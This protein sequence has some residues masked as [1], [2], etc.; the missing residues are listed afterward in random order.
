M[1]RVVLLIDQHPER[2]AALGRG[3]AEVGY[4]VIQTVSAEQGLSY[5]EALDVALVVA[6]EE[7]LGEKVSV[8]DLLLRSTTSLLLLSD[9]NELD[10]TLP[11]QARRLPLAA[12]EGAQ[13]VDRVRLMLL[14]QELGLEP[15][16]D[17]AGLVGELQ[18]DPFL[19]ITLKLESIRFSGR[20]ELPR[21]NILWYAG[22]VVEVVAGTHKG[23]KAFSRLSTQVAGAFRLVPKTRP[24]AESERFSAR[25]LIDLAIDEH[26]GRRPAPQRRLHLATISGLDASVY[27]PLGQSILETA[28]RGDTVQ[29]LLESTQLPDG[30]VLDYL[31]YMTGRGWVEVQPEGPHLTVVTDSTADLPGDLAREHGIHIVPL[32]VLFG[33]QGFRDGVDLTNARFYDLLDSSPNAPTTRPPSEAAFLRQYQALANSSAVVSL[34]ISGKLSETVTNAQAAATAHGT[35]IEVVDTG[36]VSMPLGLLALFAARMAQRGASAQEIVRTIHS[37]SERMVSRFVVDSLDYL[38]RGGRVGKARGMLG[39][40]L[41]IKP[42]LGVGDGEVVPVGQVRGG[43]AAQRKI[44]DLL[45]QEAKGQRVV[46]AI[47]HAR[48]PVW[49]DRLRTLLAAELDIAELILSEFG[50][51]VGTHTGRGTVGAVIFAP[52]DEEWAQIGPLGSLG[53]SSQPTD[54]AG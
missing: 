47:L 46:A 12:V 26:L 49:A 31:A 13:L 14:A 16:L 50:P 43:K 22:E 21:G 34:H 8:E 30:E 39:K 36:Q 9:R 52:T 28:R 19:K 51:V 11:E 44:V 25:E 1:D 17:L 45:A 42:I 38:V 10:E 23:G 4:E 7:T 2:R 5:A 40:L 33:S 48:A 15:D 3:L 18:H 41:G 54:S 53:T 29:E 20:W 37:I 27:T 24:P 35:S 6:D 32:A